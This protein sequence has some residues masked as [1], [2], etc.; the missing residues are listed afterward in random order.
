MLFLSGIGLVY[1]L[2]GTLNMADLALSVEDVENQGLLMVVAILSL[3]AFGVKAAVFPLFFWLP[4][5]Y[6]TPSFSVSSVFAE[7]DTLPKYGMVGL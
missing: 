5:A 1:G 6:H 3:F 7:G 2:T 4:A